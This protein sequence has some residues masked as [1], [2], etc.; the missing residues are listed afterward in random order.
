MHRHD[1]FPGKELIGQYR[2]VFSSA[3]GLSV[4]SHMIYDLGVFL[5][6]KSGPE[7]IALKNY[8][9]RLLKIL[10]GGDPTAENIENFTKRLMMQPL[11]KGNDEN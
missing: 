10:A 9:N 2:S 6:V 5:E 8:G 4:L 11:P 1:L 7:D 3:A